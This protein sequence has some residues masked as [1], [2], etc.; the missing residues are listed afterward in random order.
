MSLLMVQLLARSFLTEPRALDNGMSCNQA[1]T[2]LADGTFRADVVTGFSQATKKNVSLAW[3][4]ALRLPPHSKF[5]CVY[6]E[7]TLIASNQRK[8]ALH[9]HQRGFTASS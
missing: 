1:I 3:G 6:R 9:L 8:A 5:R 7:I 2:A 4:V